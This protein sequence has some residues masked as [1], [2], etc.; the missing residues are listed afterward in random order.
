MTVIAAAL[1]LSAVAGCP[2]PSGPSVVQLQKRLAALEEEAAAL[3]QRVANQQ[4]TIDEQARQI[5]ALRRLGR[6]RLARL[7][8]VEKIRFGSLSGGYDADRDGNDDGVVLYIQPVDADGDVVK[9]AGELTVRLFDFSDP[10]RPRLIGQYFFD[11]AALR[12]HWYGRFWTHH[13]TIKCP[14]REASPPQSREVTVRVEYLDYL[15]G[16]LFTESLTCKIRSTE[17]Q[18]VGL[19]R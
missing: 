3:R 4:E 9:A 2:P 13:Y 1:G 10:A 8:P 14:W 17:P 7:V 6:K 18:S 15:T 16:R 19:S 5:V 11:A 12:K